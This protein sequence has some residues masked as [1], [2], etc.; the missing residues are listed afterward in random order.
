[1]RIELTPSLSLSL[2]LFS[3]DRSM[4]FIRF[5]ILLYQY[6]PSE[7]VNERSRAKK[8]ENETKII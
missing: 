5:S 2:Y 7:W 6:V 3:F 1:M 4:R 8:N